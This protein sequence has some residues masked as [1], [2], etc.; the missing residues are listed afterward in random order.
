MSCVRSFDH[1]LFFSDLL[2]IEQ[3]KGTDQAI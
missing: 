2:S 3:Q 1:L